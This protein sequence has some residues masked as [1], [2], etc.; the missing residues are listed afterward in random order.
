[1][2][3]VPV[4]F[5]GVRQLFG[6]V[7][8]LLSLAI[9]QASAGGLPESSELH[10]STLRGQGGYWR[11][12]KTDAG[13]WWFINPKGEPDFLNMV[14]TVQPSLRGRDPNGPDFTSRDYDEKNVAALE[15]WA[16]ATIKRI[17]ETGFK[18][19]GAWS[20]PIL[21]NY[22]VPM[23]QDLNVTAWTHGGPSLIYAS[24]WSGTIEKAIEKQA[25]P[26]RENHNLVG[27]FIDNELHWDD[28]TSGPATYFDDLPGADPNRKEVIGA[29]HA[30][31][32][33]IDAFNKEW[34]TK[35][36]DWAALDAWHQLPRE[37]PAYQHLLSTWLSH[38]AETYFHTTT[39]L[40]RKHDPNHLILGVRYRGTAPAEVIHASR[41]YTDAQS[42]NYYV[43]DAKADPDLFKMISGDSEQPVVISEYSFHSLDGRS[44]D[45]N[46]VGFDAQVLDQQARADAYRLFTGRLA[47]IPYVI[48]ADWFQWMDEPPSGR[49]A[50]GEDTNFGVVDVDDKPYEKLT[51]AIRTTGP[52]LN[53]LHS[54]STDDKRQDVWRDNF[55]D[56]PTFQVPY[57]DKP[58]KINGEIS[59]WPSACRLPSMRPALA[60]G[61]DR[62]GQPE[63]NIFL[64]WNN[65]GLSLAFEVFD[66]DV[67]VSP[68]TAWWWA[69]DSVEFFVGTR[70][71]SP[72]QNV[73]DP[74]CHHF[75]F[76][77]V[78]FPSRDGTS[79]VVGRWH[80]PGDGMKE[81]LIPH[82]QIRSS[83]RILPDRYVT[84]I[85]VPAT[86]LVGW[87]PAHCPQLAFNIHVR[88][89]QHAAEFF[90]SAPKQVLTQCRPGTWGTLNLAP[91]VKPAPQQPI[92]A[93]TSAESKQ[94]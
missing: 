70:P 91:A 92:L 71:T 18:G 32:G 82:P 44:G 94:Q 36:A 50:D 74:Y 40:L 86:A 4:M 26:L 73:Y 54:G 69:R 17:T 35:L 8:L 39:T 87:D 19:I 37:A 29:I 66:K 24:G 15:S 83:T 89:Y 5:H 47:R 21:H 61:T 1:M 11:I 56:R 75:F 58:I 23:T 72:D 3:R 77:P 31:W 90:W 62:D 85:F 84:E 63:P 46:T 14:T 51:D 53:A 43:C 78:D 42:L 20:N 48:G 79:G 6:A 22:D 13:V 41:P 25:S 67:N 55:A 33:T 52:V 12:G 64:G 49:F 45:R 27:Y 76:V 68:A 2:S 57:L 30:T 80:S 65:E 7:L 10:F 34:N 81:S 38:L 59:E 93:D 60:V 28:E 16:H 9:P 88:N